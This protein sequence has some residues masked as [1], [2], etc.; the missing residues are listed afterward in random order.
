MAGISIG[1]AGLKTKYNTYSNT[2][3]W[4]SSNKSMKAYGTIKIL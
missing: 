2:L 4:T 1:S 3:Q